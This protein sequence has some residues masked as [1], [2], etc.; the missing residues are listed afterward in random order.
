MD[1]RALLGMGGGGEDGPG[2]KDVPIP[3]TCVGAAA[4]PPRRAAAAAAAAPATARP[5]RPRARSA[6][7]IYISS[8]ALLKMLKHGAC[9]PPRRGRR[10]RRRR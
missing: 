1:F 5:I 3:D 6:E 10:L 9:A 7:T 4:P 2:A 8:L